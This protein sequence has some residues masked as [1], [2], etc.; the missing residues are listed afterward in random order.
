MGGR[1][2]KADANKK[3]EYLNCRAPRKSKPQIMS[4]ACGALVSTVGFALGI[5][6]RKRPIKPTSALLRAAQMAIAQEMAK[7]LS[8][9]P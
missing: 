8:D 4:C 1:C 2:N 3:C 5:Y 9:E 7:L 6:W